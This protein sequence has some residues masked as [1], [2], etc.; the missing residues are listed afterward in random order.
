[1]RDRKH[2][3][4]KRVIFAVLSL[5]L[6]LAWA[7][8][9]TPVI[10]VVYTTAQHDRLEREGKD[11][12]RRY[13]AAIEENGGA[14]A[15]L[16]QSFDRAALDAALASLDGVLLPGGI[17]VDPKFYGE[18]RHDKLEETDAALDEL[19]FTA[20]D[21]AIERGLPVLGICRGHQVMNVHFGGSLTQD[22]PSHFEGN[23]P[24]AHRF[25]LSSKERR[26]HPIVIEEGTVLHEVFGVTRLVVNT[27]HHQAVKRL[28]DGFVV[29]ARTEDGL[30]EAIERREPPFMLGVQ[31]HP[32]RLRAKD[33]RFDALF[34]RFMDEVRRARRDRAHAESPSGDQP[35]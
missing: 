27:Y 1:M 20:L 10:G 25:P 29:S 17:D 12:L 26:E 35:R 28:A 11:D 24:V 33:A 13:R 32:E 4:C 5:C 2:S 14:V 8:A 15:V 3:R 34:A 18:D 6:A 21:Y 23:P 16:A 22:I 30:V 7:A 31:F 19:E 9:E